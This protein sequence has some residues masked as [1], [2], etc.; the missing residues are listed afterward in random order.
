MPRTPRSSAKSRIRRVSVRGILGD[1]ARKRYLE[2]RY[3]GV[4]PFGL[5]LICFDLHLRVPREVTLDAP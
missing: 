5:E 3:R 1:T 2:F 4:S